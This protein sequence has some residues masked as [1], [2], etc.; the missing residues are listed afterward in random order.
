MKIS[1]RANR[2]LKPL[3]ILARLRKIANIND[4]KLSYSGW[5]QFELNSV[6]FS[7]IDFHKNYSYITSKTLYERARDTWIKTDNSTADGFLQELNNQSILH[8]K[9]R[10]QD[11]VAVTSISIP[12]GFP[13]RYIKLSNGSI[14]CFPKGLPKKYSGRS[15]L[16]KDHW[17]K[18]G[19]ASHNGY[20]PAIIR[21]KSKN[22]TD[23][24]HLALND[25]DFIRGLFL[26]DMNSAYA[27]SL[28]GESQTRKP[29]NKITLGRMH[30]AHHPNGKL[31]TEAYWYDHD[32]FEQRA[33]TVTPEKILKAKKFFHLIHPRIQA[34][35]DGHLIKDAII[36]YT[37]AFDCLDKNYALQR[38][39]SA[40]ESIL[41]P[42]ENNTD[43][44]VRRASFLYADRD[45]QHQVLEHLKDYR[46]R[47]VHTGNFIEAP[48]E[49]CY[50]VQRF[51]RQ[52]VIF[53]SMNNQYF[54]SLREGNEFLDFPSDIGTLER[55]KFLIEK[56]IRFLT[57]KLQ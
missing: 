7:M 23:G 54:D 9:S 6:L 49:Y 28:R 17:P 30:T 40:L 53:H 10:E 33:R 24:M 44:V 29:I 21:F 12:N 31:V 47:S 34:H 35:K 16:E 3:V 18:N 45:Y 38:T 14:Q 37:R 11:F 25:L 56:A 41:A 13:T 50:Q 46:N 36:R 8:G 15:A 1:W 51:F 42:G 20:C 22:I 48:D 4:G 52:A 27:L 32:Y 39:W 19:A 55:K 26:L 43:M 2:K 5:E 57:P